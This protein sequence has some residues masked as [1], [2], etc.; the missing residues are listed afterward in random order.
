MN[1]GDVSLFSYVCPSG[2]VNTYLTRLKIIRIAVD[3]DILLFIFLVK[4]VVY[5][6]KIMLDG[7]GIW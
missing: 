6:Y 1:H 3:Q 4:N 2:T 7:P 5:D